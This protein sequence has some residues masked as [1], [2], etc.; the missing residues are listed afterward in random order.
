M[1]RRFDETRLGG[2]IEVGLLGSPKVTYEANQIFEEFK[3]KFGV[4]KINSETGLTFYFYPKKHIGKAMQM[5]AG[6]ID[7]GMYE[8][9]TGKFLQSVRNAVNEKVQELS[10]NN[11]KIDALQDLQ[12][13][14]YSTVKTPIDLLG[15]DAVMDFYDKSKK[16]H[17]FIGIDVT[18]NKDKI[19]G[20]KT[21]N[22]AIIFDA[23]I[24]PEFQEYQYRDEMN[25]LASTIISKA[26]NHDGFI[27]RGIDNN[28]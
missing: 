10:E 22:N 18:A 1:V 20:F 12:W 4:Q 25:Q 16:Q 27:V 23:S 7:N 6:L 28:D 9:S 8:P 26:I 11:P 21:N 2:A 13:K 17:M 19:E 5:L 3:K 24:D 14:M 15:V